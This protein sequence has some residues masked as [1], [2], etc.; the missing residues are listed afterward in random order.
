MDFTE[1]LSEF[2]QNARA[3]LAA[4]ILG[5]MSFDTTADRVEAFKKQG[6]GM[7]SY[8]LQ[9]PQAACWADK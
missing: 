7:Q 3:R 9:L 2:P 5:S 6:W 4:E 1:V 8:I